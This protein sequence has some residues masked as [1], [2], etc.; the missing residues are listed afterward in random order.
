VHR[1]PRYRSRRS[2]FLIGDRQNDLEAARRAGMPGFLFEAAAS[3][4]YFVRDLLGG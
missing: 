4:R 1:R 2:R 3:N